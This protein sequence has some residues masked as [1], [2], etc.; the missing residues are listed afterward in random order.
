MIMNNLDTALTRSKLRCILSFLLTSI[1]FAIVAVQMLRCSSAILKYANPQSYS[2]LFEDVRVSSFFL[3]RIILN[4]MQ[5]LYAGK[6]IVWIFFKSLSVVDVLIVTMTLMI[7]LQASNSEYV[8]MMRIFTGAL[9]IILLI[10]FLVYTLFL[11]LASIQLTT[12]AG[13]AHLRTGALIGQYF[14]IA[15]ILMCFLMNA[16]LCLFKK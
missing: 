5:Y 12:E 14:G 2:R 4:A 15:M 8:Y 9:F 3:G 16:V 1:L 11:F 13:F 6:G 7:L 10:S